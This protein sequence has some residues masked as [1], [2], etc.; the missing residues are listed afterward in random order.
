MAHG[1]M[2]LRLMIDDSALDYY[3]YDYDYDYT[4]TYLCVVPANLNC[5]QLGSIKL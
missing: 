2:R 3:M 1:L 4:T 5:E